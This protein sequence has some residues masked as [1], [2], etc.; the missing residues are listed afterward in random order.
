MAKS[1]NAEIDLAMVEETQRVLSPFTL[2]LDHLVEINPKN[3]GFYFAFIVNDQVVYDYLSISNRV[4]GCRVKPGRFFLSNTMVQRLRDKHY[5]RWYYADRDYVYP[6]KKETYQR[7][8][9]RFLCIETSDDLCHVQTTIVD[10]PAMYLRKKPL[11]ANR[12]DPTTWD[13]VLT[14]ERYLE[15]A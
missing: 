13:D 6:L 12:P 5:K 1:S 15:T 14:E 3:G 11:V 4:N 7:F 8:V 10:P 2:K 9:D